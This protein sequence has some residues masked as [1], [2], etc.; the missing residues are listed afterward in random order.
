MTECS[1]KDFDYG[2][3]Y[4][5]KKSQSEKL[6]TEEGWK[7]K[8]VKLVPLNKDY[9][10]IVLDSKADYRTIGVLKCV[11]NI[12]MSRNIIEIKKGKYGTTY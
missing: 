3:M 2:D 4:T 11:L 5:I 8:N 6:V 12:V 10:T 1:K 7:H 9:E